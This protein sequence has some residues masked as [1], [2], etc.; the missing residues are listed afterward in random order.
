MGLLKKAPTLKIAG[1]KAH[2]GR[3]HHRLSSVRTGVT[4]SRA[5]REEDLRKYVGLSLVT[6]YPPAA[7]AQCSERSVGTVFVDWSLGWRHRSAFQLL[8]RL[9]RGSS[10]CRRLASRIARWYCLSTHQMR[11]SGILR[12]CILRSGRVRSH[13]YSRP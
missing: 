12:S 7:R 6:V 5:A 13:R 10:H 2:D 1:S 8:S 4:V 11:K 9:T 3:V